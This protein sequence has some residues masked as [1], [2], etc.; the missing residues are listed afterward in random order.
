MKTQRFIITGMSC[1]SCISHIEKDVGKLD[2]VKSISVNLPAERAE[3]IF[4]EKK[5][6]DQDIIDQVK[7]TGY[8]ASIS[9]AEKQQGTHHDHASS[10]KAASTRS[11]WNKMIFGIIMSVGITILMFTPA[12]PFKM[13]LMALAALSVLLYTG[14][15][16]FLR[17][18][19]SLFKGRPQMDT[20]IA[21]GSSAA[22]LYS[23]YSVFI[24]NSHN[25]YFMDAAFIS[26]FV[27]MGRYL[28]ERTKNQAGSA[29]K[30]L[31]GLSAKKAHLVIGKN[32]TRD[33]DI[34][35]VKIGDN[36]LVKPG[37]KIPTDGI[38]ITGAVTLD[39]S[40]VTGESVPVEK[41]EGDKV[42]GATVNGNTAM[43]IEVKKIGEETLLSQMIEL[44][45][46]AQMS[47]AP[48]QKLVDII[49]SYFVWG[50]LL[51]A[52][53][54]F[55]AWT[56]HGL[57]MTNSL[58]ITVSVL[59]IACPCALGLAT[60]ISIV[61]G[62]GKGAQLGILIKRSES[63]EKVHQITTICFDKT[64]TIT[65]G[66]PEM[67]SF[68]ALGKHKPKEVLEA[69]YALELQSEHPLAKSIVEYCQKKKIAAIEVKKFRAEIGLGVTGIVN[70]KHYFLG[71]QKYMTSLSRPLNGAER[72]C[73]DLHEQGQTVLFVANSKEVIG[74][75]AVA[76]AVKETSRKAVKLLHD[77]GIKMVMMTGDHYQV[78]QAI[79]KEVGIDEVIAEVSPQQKTKKI[80]SL[81]K[82]GEIVA[83]VG[84]GINDSPALATADVGIAMGTG[85]DVA[86]ESGDIVLV[87]G[88]L[89]KAVEAIELS[90]ATLR[91]IKQ[92]L[93]WAFIYNSLG[94]PIAAL[95]FLNP[96]VSSVAMGF[97]SLTV[98]LNALR[99]KWFQVKHS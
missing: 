72:Y 40:M 39:E 31:M 19:P 65:K 47:K 45:R 82:K 92:N 25:E 41:K 54:T 58:L 23:M 95:G 43:S 2:G 63:L 76:D 60:P 84:D 34:T 6:T 62:S 74:F 4:D 1:A 27:M 44:V 87:K 14:N 91:N 24:L 7:K 32:K 18:I 73:E 81:Q 90:E 42:I 21:L 17:G 98:V 57:D 88:D 53:V 86:M 12:L 3:V 96:I 99:L 66:H 55:S 68:Q 77:R 79:A 36:L 46:Q 26:T 20:L 35:E 89:M 50:V 11:K 64:G 10:E 22:F 71:S 49:S 28:E 85:T 94:I 93:F 8:T 75:F 70:K 83:M 5:V 33:I 51:I 30:K 56:W 29:I 69:A 9:I 37:E 38:I 78:A 59:V 48:I 80:K 52:V 15:E 67:Q 13:D 97:S 61:V 16:Y